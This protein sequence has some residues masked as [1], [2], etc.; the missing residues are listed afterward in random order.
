MN[1]REENKQVDM[2]RRSMI[3]CV[4]I[5]N[6]SG[7][8]GLTCCCIW[9]KLPRCAM[10]EF[11]F[12]LRFIEIPETPCR[13]AGFWKFQEQRTKNKGGRKKATAAGVR[14]QERGG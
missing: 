1:A 8:G 11:G 14:I 10:S 7:S 9:L 6:G 2:T 3:Y 5:K 12:P 13:A 4:R